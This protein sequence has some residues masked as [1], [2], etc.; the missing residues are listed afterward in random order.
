MSIGSIWRRHP[1]KGLAP[2]G[3]HWLGTLLAIALCSI[4][5]SPAAAAEAMPYSNALLWKIEAPGRAPSYVFGTMHI[6]DKRVTTLPKP[7]QEA[8]GGVNDL[9]LELDF[10][11]GFGDYET[12]LMHLPK[13]QKLSDILGDKLFAKVKKRLGADPAK[14]KNLERLKPWVVLLALGQRPLGPESP[15]AERRLP[16]D[17][18]LASIALK[19]GIPVFGIETYTEQLNVFDK[20]PESDQVRM[21]REAVD[22]SERDAKRELEQMIHL[23]VAR[24][25]AGLFSY[26]HKLDQGSIADQAAFEKR[27]I[28]DRNRVMARRVEN[29]LIDGGAFIAVGAAHLPGEKG[30]LNLLAKRGYKVEPVY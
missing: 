22:A 10:G 19:H 24:D 28:D 9:S 6:S 21:I 15:E 5:F 26:A 1:V 12:R 14:N 20:V 3:A 30:L 17:L 2:N 8:L 23:Y 29:V 25:L 11:S 18:K 27:M 13:K 4:A 7:V 16:L